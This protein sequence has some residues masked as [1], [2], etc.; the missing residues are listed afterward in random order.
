MEVQRRVWKQSELEAMGLLVQL[1]I[2]ETSIVLQKEVSF[3]LGS[4]DE[5]NWINVLQGAEGGTKT[6]HYAIE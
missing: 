2:D 5:T 3:M 1:T 4:K 6:K